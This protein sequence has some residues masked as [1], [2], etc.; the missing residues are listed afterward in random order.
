K[1]QKALNAFRNA[2][3]MNYDLKIQEDAWLNYAKIR[4]DIE[5]PY[6]SLSQVLTSYLNKYP[7]TA[8]TAAVE[9][10]SIDYYNTSKNYQAAFKFM[11]GKNSFEYRLAYQK[12]AFY[13][14]VEVYNESNYKES[15]GLFE[16]SM[17]EAKDATFTARATF[18]N[19]ETDYHLSNYNA[20]LIGF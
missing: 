18:W 14:G 9:A 19:A 16:K 17:K 12:V 8:Y 15:K 6:Q 13:R 1:K 10:L 5:N 7:Q 4:Y 2:S 11:E 20:A 3:Q